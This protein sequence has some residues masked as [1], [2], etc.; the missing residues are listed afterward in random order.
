ML[1]RRHSGG[2]DRSVRT[3]CLE[4]ALLDQYASELGQ[5]LPGRFTL[6]LQIVGKIAS[7]PQTACRAI[8]ASDTTASVHA[9]IESRELLGC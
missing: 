9:S 6:E 1:A 2:G 5:D 3:A 4:L 7:R 8:R